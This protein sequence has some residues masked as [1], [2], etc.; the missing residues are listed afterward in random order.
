MVR[1][2]GWICMTALLVFLSCSESEASVASRSQ[3]TGGELEAWHRFLED[4]AFR[5]EA[6]ERSLENPENG[7]S[8]T[9]L[10]QYREDRWG[11]LPEW[12]PRVRRVHPS[13]LGNGRPTPDF[14][15]QS[16]DLSDVWD[17]ETLLELGLRTFTTFPSQISTAMLT[18]LEDSAG[19]ARYG[20]WQTG[21]WV[22]G[23]LWV[24]LPDGVLPAF[25]CATC[26]ASVDAKGKMRWGLPNY[27]FDL[28]RALDDFQRTRTANRTWG[29]GRV[30]VTPDGIVNPTV[31]ADLR[32]VRYQSHL[33]RAATIQNSLM[34]LAVRLE[35]NSITVTGRAVRAPRLSILANAV[36]LHELAAL[37]PEVPEGPGRAVFDAHC[38]RCHA[39]PGFAGYPTALD[40]VG[41][42][43]SIGKSSSRTTGAYQTP[44]LRGVADRKMLTA[45]GVF[46]SVEALLDPERAVPGHPYGQSLSQKDRALLAGFLH[47]L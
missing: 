25:S 5:R 30:D 13:D 15:W 22:G 41:T 12:N 8:R 44:S 21:D 36:F 34:G 39:P 11:S 4:P 37:L 42:D 31:I 1:L 27:D 32:P 19:P 29:P 17:E 28:G 16:L 45:T 24:E 20:L 35:T 33:Q 18:A 43:P 9:R 6:L 40:T 7:Y 47:A 38:A 3:D 46:H 2:P 23:L 10:E 26:H 14:T